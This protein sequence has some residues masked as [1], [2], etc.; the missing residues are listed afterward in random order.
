MCSLYKPLQFDVIKSRILKNE[1]DVNETVS[2]NNSLFA[3]AVQQHQFEFASWLLQEGANPCVYLNLKSNDV[4]IFPQDQRQCYVPLVIAKYKPLHL[5]K[6]CLNHP[7]ISVTSEMLIVF[8][9]G[10]GLHIDCPTNSTD[11]LDKNKAL[12]IE[13]A[14]QMASSVPLHE[15]RPLL[16]S[17]ILGRY[18]ILFVPELLQKLNDLGFLKFLNYSTHLAFSTW[19]TSKHMKWWED[20]IITFCLKCLRSYHHHIAIKHHCNYANFVTVCKVPSMSCVKFDEL[21]LIHKLIDTAYLNMKAHDLLY[22]EKVFKKGKVPPSP[23]M[24]MRK[25]QIIKWTYQMYENFVK[26]KYHPQ[27]QYMINTFKTAL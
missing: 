6:Q 19:D 21:C 11:Y 18:N 24:T 17:H 23:F 7:D 25:K 5:L 27:S 20:P 2:N 16:L 3:L 9:E 13:I 22:L 14:I 8:F 15:R 10:F 12:V 26:R 1:L 4:Q